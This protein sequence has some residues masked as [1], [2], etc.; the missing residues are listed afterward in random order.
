MSE[1]SFNEYIK[2]QQ[3]YLAGEIDYEQASVS[4]DAMGFSYLEADAVLYTA[5]KIL[6]AK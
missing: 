6:E 2:I 1:N 5:R 3:Q 4:L